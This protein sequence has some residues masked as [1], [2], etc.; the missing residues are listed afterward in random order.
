[1]A[2]PL[3][4]SKREV[5]HL[6]RPQLAAGPEREDRPERRQSHRLGDLEGEQRHLP[7]RRRQADSV[8]RAR[9]A[10]A[11]LPG[12]GRARDA[13]RHADRQDPD[14]AR[15]GR[16][17]VQDRTAG[18]SERPVHPVRDPG[19][20]ADIRHHPRQPALQP[21]G[22]AGLRQGRQQRAV[23]LWLE[24]LAAG[25]RDHGEGGLEAPRRGRRSGPLPQGRGPG[26]HAHGQG[27]GAAVRQARPGRASRP[28]A[29][30]IS[31][32][33]TPRRPRWSN[34][35]IRRRCRSPGRPTPRSRTRRGRPRSS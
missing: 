9:R 22:P 17:A 35:P 15:G 4:C 1:M 23:R 8:R 21:G 24:Q 10:A 29:T 2:W 28:T 31:S 27:P 13:R 19:Q 3:P 14:P 5:S 30:T 26:L 7:A 20:R 16:P 11:R 25:R 18:R 6:H 33:S 12:P 32:A 34:P